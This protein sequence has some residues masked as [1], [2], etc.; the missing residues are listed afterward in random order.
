MKFNS[1]DDITFGERIR[2]LRLT[3]KLTQ[4]SLAAKLGVD[5]TYLSKIENNR[6]GPPAE[7]VIRGLAELLD[8]PYESLMLRARRVPTHYAEKI[9][10]DPLVADFMR[11]ASK[12]T[13][14]Q[15]KKIR[16]ILGTGRDAKENLSGT[17]GQGDP[18]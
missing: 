14:E 9:T 1:M 18:E 3:R 17:Q 15:R 10:G 16:E 8:E 7:S 12:L 11:S 2:Q 4:P 5:V 6:V 13:R